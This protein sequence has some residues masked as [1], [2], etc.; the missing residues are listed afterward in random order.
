M[1]FNSR[2]TVKPLESVVDSVFTPF[3]TTG[4]AKPL[5]SGATA[6][7]PARPRRPCERF[8][9]SRRD[10]MRAV[11]EGRKG[12]V[13]LELEGRRG[14]PEL[15]IASRNA[16]KLFSVANHNHGNFDDL[17]KRT[18]RSRNHFLGMIA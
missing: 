10:A 5:R 7:R 6:L 13:D 1:R 4:V 2:L 9:A 17:G 11:N 3:F 8:K 15:K 18:A 16:L 12:K 14:I